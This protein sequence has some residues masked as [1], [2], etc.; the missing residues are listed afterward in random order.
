[1]K[2]ADVRVGVIGTG[3]WGRNLVRNF[4]ELGALAGL[5]DIN[6]AVRED[7][8]AG[9]PEARMYE[10]ADQMLG[11]PGIDAIAIATPAATHGDLADAA[12]RAGKHVFVEKPMCLEVDQAEHLRDT[13]RT[14]RLTLMV[15][16]LLLYHPAFCALQH[17]VESSTAGIGQLRYIYSNRLSLGRI[18]REEKRTLVVRAARCVDDP[19]SHA[20]DAGTRYRNRKSPPVARG[21][22][23]DIVPLVVSRRRPSAYLRILAPSLQRSPHG[24]GRRERNDRL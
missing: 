17:I 12:L 3:Y 16:H 1:M 2:D 15:G 21:P 11:D 14:G 4:H 9:Y 6:A 8:S 7:I 22:R 18:R 10:Q 5:S 13:A 24:R 19:R 20:G 23:Y